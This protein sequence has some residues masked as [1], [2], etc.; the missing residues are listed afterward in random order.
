MV[1]VSYP[2][3]SEGDTDG[4]ASSPGGPERPFGNEFRKRLRT[5]S[6]G[7]YEIAGLPPGDLTIVSVRRGRRIP[8]QRY[9][10]AEGTVVTADFVIPD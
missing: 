10:L 1:K 5:D 2:R 7:S 4:L 3:V 8:V 9:K 6:T